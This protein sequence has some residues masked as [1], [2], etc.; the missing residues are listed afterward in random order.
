MRSTGNNAVLVPDGEGG[1][2]LRGTFDLTILEAT[3]IYAPFVGGHNLMVDNLHL[4]R[5]KAPPMS[6]ASATSAIHEATVVT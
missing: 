2:F 1:N 3:G 6:T 4:L 5:L